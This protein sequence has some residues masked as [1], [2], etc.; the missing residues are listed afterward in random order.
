[1]LL[2]SVRVHVFA[3]LPRLAMLFSF[4]LAF[5]KPIME[6]RLYCQTFPSHC[7]ICML[8]MSVSSLGIFKS[9][10]VLFMFVPCRVVLGVYNKDVVAVMMLGSLTHSLHASSH[11]MLLSFAFY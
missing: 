4:L 6:W 8:F 10:Y 3:C 11:S 5:L 2:W 7:H 1:M 9:T